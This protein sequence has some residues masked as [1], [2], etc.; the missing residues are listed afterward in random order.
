[1]RE[2]F[3]LIEQPTLNGFGEVVAFEE[4]R[5]LIGDLNSSEAFDTEQDVIENVQA[6]NGLIGKWMHNRG[7]KAAS[8]IMDLMLD[9]TQEAHRKD[10]YTPKSLHMLTQ[11]V[12]FISCLE[13]G[14]HVEDPEGVLALIFAHD[15]GEDYGITPEDID[16]YLTENGIADRRLIDQLKEDFDV[17]TKQY[18]NTET[19]QKGPMKY[20]GDEE[21]NSALARSQ[22]A[23]IAKMFDRAHNIMTLIGVQKLKKLKKYMGHIIADQP[24]Y[25]ATAKRNFPSQADLYDVL[26]AIIEGEAV[27]TQVEIDI[28]EQKSI[29]DGTQLDILNNTPDQGFKNMPSGLHPYEVIADRIRHQYPHVFMDDNLDGQEP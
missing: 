5:T 23:S 4:R 29:G 27:V 19:S 12:W 21:Y 26:E 22:N 10:D 13:D 14:L 16:V 6:L 28:A 25:A 20:E 18:R 24:E 9:K 17:I 3:V 11:A 2:N 15:L 8:L 1:M 7:F